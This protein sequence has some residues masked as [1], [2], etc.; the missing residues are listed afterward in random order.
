VTS[1]PPLDPEERRLLLALAREAVCRGVTGAPLPEIEACKVPPR[2]AEPVGCFVTLTREGVL[3]GCIG[4]LEPRWPLWQAVLE[5][6]RA[7]ATRDRRFPPVAPDEVETLRIEISVL[8]PPQP[9]VC[10]SPDALLAQLAPGRDGVLLE[11]GARRATFLP[12]VW[13]KL[14]DKV[15]FLDQLA[16]KAGGTAGDWWR[17]DARVSIYAVEH[18]A[19]PDEPGAAPDPPGA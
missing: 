5:N 19:E 14:T 9:L 10:D 7:A 6:A 2:L 16:L 3:R 17:P 18:F 8:T 4:N 13:D 15:T 1:R 12:Q 11:L